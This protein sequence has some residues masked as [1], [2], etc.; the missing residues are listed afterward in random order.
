MEP[1][2]ARSTPPSQDEPAEERGGPATVPDPAGTG[3]SAPDLSGL[4][5]AGLSRRRVAWLLAAIV[6]VW[7]V[8][9][10]ARQV[11][12]AAAATDRAD[13]LRLDN[14]TLVSQVDDLQKELDLIGRQ[15][16]IEQ[17]ARAY[18]L[19]ARTERP[20]TLGPDASALPADAPGS[21][22]VRLGAV[23]A[24]SAPLDVW[25]DLLFGPSR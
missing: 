2:R 20:F 13:R 9:V 4:S 12:D 23:A 21:A 18:G 10:F 1:K 14:A 5:I 25:L 17:Q 8:A 19:G 15:A 24:H 11:G 6:S 7:I 16:F 3:F 22:G